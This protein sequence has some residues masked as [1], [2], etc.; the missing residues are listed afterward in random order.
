MQDS[1]DMDCIL[2]CRAMLGRDSGDTLSD[3]SGGGVAPVNVGD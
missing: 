2:V 1:V 3:V